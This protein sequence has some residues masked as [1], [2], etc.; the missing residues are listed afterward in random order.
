MSRLRVAGGSGSRDFSGLGVASREADS[1]FRLEYIC[2]PS[3]VCGADA[4]GLPAD[5]AG[6]A[7][8]E[9]SKGAGLVAERGVQAS[10]VCGGNAWNGLASVFR[11][12][13]PPN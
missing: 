8:R 6:L 3:P 5:G 1:D 11:Q 13:A 2:R 4:R 10:K 9:F 12:H 7:Y